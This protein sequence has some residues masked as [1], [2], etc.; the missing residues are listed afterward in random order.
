[1]NDQ[2]AEDRGLL[3]ASQDFQDSARLDTLM[4]CGL[5]QVLKGL[6]PLMEANVQVKH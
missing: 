1:M 5:R 4:L 3:G 6:L 2:V